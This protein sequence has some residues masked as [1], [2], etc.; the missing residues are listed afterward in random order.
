MPPTT[1]TSRI[2]LQLENEIKRLV[3]ITSIYRNGDFYEYKITFE[4]FP[5]G[6]WI[7]VKKAQLHSVDGFM[8]SAGK[9]IL[10]GTHIEIGYHLDGK[11]AYK[12]VGGEWNIKPMVSNTPIRK[13]SKPKIF[14]RIAGFRIND[15]INFN[16]A[17]TGEHYLLN[18]PPYDLNTTLT[19]D[20][21]ISK[22]QSSGAVYGLTTGRRSP[23][24]NSHHINFEDVEEGID[25]HL[26]F[27]ETN[28]S[29]GPYFSIVRNDWWGTVRQKILYFLYSIKKFLKE[30]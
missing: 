6:N 28:V 23:F 24:Q 13:I 11:T 8:G 4:G 20:F 7:F 16:R 1:T 26:H 27:Y 2:L 5:R 12:D 30:I 22:R 25:L 14:F 9:R 21:H 29:G 17:P 15:L 3:N 19:C 10:E 18:A